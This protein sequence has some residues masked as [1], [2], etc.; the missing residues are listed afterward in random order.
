[1]SAVNQYVLFHRRESLA[2]VG[3]AAQWRVA[4]ERLHDREHPTVIPGGLAS[5]CKRR[6]GW[7]GGLARPPTHQPD[8]EALGRAAAR[9]RGVRRASAA[10]NSI[11]C[12]PRQ[13]RAHEC[14]LPRSS[15]R[16]GEAPTSALGSRGTHPRT[17]SAL[18]RVSNGPE[19]VLSPTG[20]CG[21]SP[22]FGV[23]R[24][25]RA[26]RAAWVSAAGRRSRG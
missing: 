25:G 1:M 16:A 3:H 5:T 8:D 6:V 7:V 14:G 4:K 26:T 23:D 18:C 2:H 24:H 15:A 10:T 21:G 13:P 17:G 11:R 20:F 9:A 19:R 22:F 12:G